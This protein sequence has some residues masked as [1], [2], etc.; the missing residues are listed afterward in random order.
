[1]KTEDL[2]ALGA[3]QRA[4]F[5]SQ[6]RALFPVFEREALLRRD[7][8]RLD[9]IRDRS[10]TSEIAV[11]QINSFG[12]EELWEQWLKA[13]RD[14]LNSELA[15]TLAV[16]FDRVQSAKKE[17]GRHIALGLI[18][19]NEEKQNAQRRRDRVDQQLLG[20]VTL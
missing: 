9:Q 1:M 3:A 14:D 11:S 8:K 19:G 13:K 16:K 20:F 17:L 18:T 10:R 2:R 5:E 12:V 15:T 6:K 7:L 4:I